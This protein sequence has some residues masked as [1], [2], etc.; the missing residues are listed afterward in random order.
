MA[1]DYDVIV[2]EGA[3]SPAEINLM[4][5]DLV[6]MGMAGMIDAPVLLVG[7]IDRGGVFASLAG[8]MLLFNEKDRAEVK[9]VIINKF[10]GDLE[11]LR[12]GLSMLEDIIKV[13]VVGVVPYMKLNVDDEDSLTSRFDKHTARGAYRCG[14]H[15]AAEDIQFY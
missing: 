4:E 15:K 14:S 11:I 3:G 12:P 10:R 1:E 7:D 5:N 8:T 13:P 9:G 6:N 2:L